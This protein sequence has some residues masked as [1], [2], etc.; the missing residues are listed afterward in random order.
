MDLHDTHARLLFLEIELLRLQAKY[1][2][3]VE[4]MNSITAEQCA[5]TLQINQTRTKLHKLIHAEALDWYCYETSNHFA[6]N[7][8]DKV[9]ALTPKGI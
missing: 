4:Q 2:T 5:V 7:N 6:A 3:N 8:A 9:T 1:A